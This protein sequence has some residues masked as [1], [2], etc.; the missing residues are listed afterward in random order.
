[1]A[2]FVEIDASNIVLR[3]VVLNDK[4]TQDESGNDVESIGAKYL[5]DLSNEQLLEYG[6]D[7][8]EWIKDGEQFRES[9][10]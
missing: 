2:S 9:E 4:D 3:G 10:K 7:L 1:M 5:S 6:K 8:K